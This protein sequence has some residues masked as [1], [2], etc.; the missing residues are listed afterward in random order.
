MTKKAL[1]V[2]INDY[3]KFNSN[4]DLRG[5]INDTLDVRDFLINECGFL[6]D[7]IQLLHD[8][9]ATRNSILKNLESLFHNFNKNDNILVFH[10]SGHGS[11]VKDNTGT[12]DDGLSEILIPYDHDWNNPLLDKDLA[13]II[14][15]SSEAKRI[16]IL[17]CCHSGT[18]T[19]NFFDPSYPIK[20][21]YIKPPNDIMAEMLPNGS[22]NDFTKSSERRFWEFFERILVKTG[23]NERNI[24]FTDQN[25]IVLAACQSNQVAADSWIESARLFQGAFTHYLMEIWRRIKYSSPE[26]NYR[27]LIQST[28]RRLKKQ[29]YSQNPQ[30]EMPEIMKGLKTIKGQ[31]NG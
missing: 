4:S 11:Q 6:S 22:I 19:R 8:S 10:F 18:G 17:D 14:D 23:K 7:D 31:K 1:L 2:G 25:C 30:L 24:T 12:E 21:K 27:N 28:A 20:Y 3:S 29:G 13:K 15:N 16:V 26:D 9:R 5:C